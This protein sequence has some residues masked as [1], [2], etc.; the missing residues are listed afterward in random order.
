MLDNFRHA[1]E[2]APIGI[3]LTTL[4]G[5]IIQ[6]NGVLQKLLGLEHK[7][8]Q[9]MA[10]DDLVHPHDMATCAENYQAL[11]S[12]Q[13]NYRL[14]GRRYLRKDG[15]YLNCRV[16]AS[17]ARDGQDRPMFFIDMVE[18]NSVSKHAG[19]H[20]SIFKELFTSAPDAIVLCD[21]NGLIELANTH[22]EKIFGYEASELWGLPIEMLFAEKMRLRHS[23]LRHAQPIYAP[24]H[25]QGP[26]MTFLAQRKDGAEFPIEVSIGQVSA[27]I[28]CVVRDITHRDEFHEQLHRLAFHDTLTGLPN[29]A[30]FNEHL[31]QAMA[32][33]KRH[34]HLVGLM[35]L[36][37]DRFK[38][39][40]DTM[41]HETGDLLLKRA[42]ER[43]K[44]RMRKGDT[45][46]RLGGDEFAIILA[47]LHHAE[48]GA[49]VAQK[50][51][52]NFSIPFPVTDREMFVTVSIGITLYPDD[53]DSI[54]GLLRNADSAMYHAKEQGRNNYQFYSPEM[55]VRAQQRFMLETGLRMA[56]AKNQFVLHYQVQSDLRSGQTIGVEAL[57]RWNHPELG[58]I[59]PAQFIPLA[60]ETGLI[61][62]LGEWVLR[63]AC[64]EAFRWYGSD[65]R[66]AVNFSS[67]QFRQSGMADMITHILAE[68]GFDPSRLELEITESVLLEN[69]DSVHEMLAVLKNMGVR[70]SIDDFGTGYS[71]LL[72]LKRFPIDALKIDRSF[73][74][75][76]LTDPDDAAI[77]RSIIALARILHMDVIAEGVETLEQ[78]AF[79]RGEGCFEM[80]GYLLGLPVVA[81][82]I[83][84][85]LREAESR[86][87]E[88]VNAPAGNTCSPG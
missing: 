38:E 59:Q 20:T 26:R 8:W 70:I 71:S 28:I 82:E 11:A 18:R 44:A 66:L 29:R 13:S 81:E 21:T 72:Y 68:T 12:G 22:A 35:F 87:L 40:N 77:V 73:I 83:A 85:L 84:S 15:H 42:A 61:V 36:D 46:A 56:L 17:V 76:I 10:I 5:K 32:E 80:Q 34:G 88:N 74:Q 3:L 67:R 45:V 1:C 57:V 43:L 58:L 47:N 55:T 9:G 49:D 63:T 25:H 86:K 14:A 65:I 69:S 19:S 37:I 54:K 4:S 24:A 62:Q 48:D 33:A 79:L 78:A 64:V 23:I 31:T 6:I 51:I 52:E 53:N 39:V 27:G 2:H 75:D 50:I 41:G 16:T 30:L 7:E 60:E